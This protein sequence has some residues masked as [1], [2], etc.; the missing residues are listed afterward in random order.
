MSYKVVTVVSHIWD[1]RTS[2]KPED[3]GLSEAPPKEVAGLGSKYLFNRS[4]LTP[5]HSAR[6]ALYRMLRQIGLPLGGGVWLIEAASYRENAEQLARQIEEFHKER[7]WLLSNFLV[8]YRLWHDNL[9]QKYSDIPYQP[10]KAH[11]LLERTKIK[12]LTM[13]V[14]RIEDAEKAGLAAILRDEI[15]E[16]AGKLCKQLKNEKATR[17]ALNPVARLAEKIK[18]L[19]FLDKDDYWSQPLVDLDASIKESRAQIGHFSASKS[20]VVREL[21]S[22]IGLAVVEV[23][24]DVDLDEASE[25]NNQTVANSGVQN[26]TE[27]NLEAPALFENEHESAPEIEAELE[28]TTRPQICIFG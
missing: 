18:S 15:R 22:I 6:S 19:A 3:L 9:S 24:P 16:E 21:T 11:A 12:L 4:L 17:R 23:L 27:S 28:R 5:M 2:L 25:S 10:G 14:E 26:R 13:D 7:D 8:Q 20:L 1:A